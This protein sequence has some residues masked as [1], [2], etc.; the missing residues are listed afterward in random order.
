[1]LIKSLF[2]LFHLPYLPFSRFVP[3][4]FWLSSLTLL[5]S[6]FYPCCLLQVNSMPFLVKDIFS[7]TSFHL[8]FSIF[9]PLS[10]PFRFHL[11]HHPPSHTLSPVKDTSFWKRKKK[12]YEYCESLFSFYPLA[13]AL[14]PIHKDTW[15]LISPMPVRAGQHWA[16]AGRLP[17]YKHT[18]WI[19]NKHQQPCVHRHT[20]WLAICLTIC[21]LRAS[22]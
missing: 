2:I 14:P 13:P 12:S 1:M 7:I 6:I 15:V 10:P 3:S 16:T 9:L 20:M 22:T 4:L 18:V 8:V 11:F 19:R 21:L 5:Y 17:K